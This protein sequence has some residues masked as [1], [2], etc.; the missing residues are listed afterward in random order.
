MR[1]TPQM[2]EPENL[3]YTRA[4]VVSVSVGPKSGSGLI[5]PRQIRAVGSG[6]CHRD[7]GRRAAGVAAVSPISAKS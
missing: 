4:V 6:V 5:V 1:P 2:V 3:S 7:D